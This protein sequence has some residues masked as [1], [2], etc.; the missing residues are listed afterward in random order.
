[1]KDL[2]TD[3]GHRVFANL[4]DL[5]LRSV[6]QRYRI[7]QLVNGLMESHRKG[8][9]AL[10]DQ[11]GGANFVT[12]FHEMGNQALVGLV[13]FV[14]GEKDP[15]NLM[16][17]FSMLKVIMV[18]WDISDHV[19][20]SVLVNCDSAELTCSDVVSLC[21]LLLS[22]YVQTSSKRPLWHHR[23]GS[24]E[25]TARLHCVKFRIRSLRISRFV[26]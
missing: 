10:N 14:S 17:V 4:Q 23:T 2:R 24:Q 9:V 7:Y 6:G 15:K 3:V 25:Q 20:A 1:L 18:E 11:E 26:Q 16:L 8:R 19:E 22:Y 21:L 12:A 13:D 5:Q